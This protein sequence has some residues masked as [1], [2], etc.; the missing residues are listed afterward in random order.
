MIHFGVACRRIKAAKR[1]SASCR[2]EASRCFH[3]HQW[4][5]GCSQPDRG[6]RCHLFSPDRGSFLRIQFEIGAS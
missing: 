3:K 6:R 2:N 4:S 5:R 1:R